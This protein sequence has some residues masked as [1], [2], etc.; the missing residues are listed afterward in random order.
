MR[1]QN[2]SYVPEEGYK[3][4]SH[5]W[6]CEG[7]TMGVEV[8]TDTEGGEKEVVHDVEC[9]YVITDG[10]EP[11]DCGVGDPKKHNC[12]QMLKDMSKV[13][14]PFY[15]KSDS[16]LSNGVELVSHPMTLRYV[17]SKKDE[18][19]KWRKA[20]ISNGFRCWDQK[21]AGI[22]IHTPLKNWSKTQLYRMMWLLYNTEDFCW[23]WCNRDESARNYCKMDCQYT[24]AKVAKSTRTE[25][26]NQV[27]TFSSKGTIEF[28]FFRSTSKITT[29]F[30]YFELI[31]AIYEY[32]RTCPFSSIREKGKDCNVD[33]K[34]F[35]G[36]QFKMWLGVMEHRYPNLAKKAKRW[37]SCEQKITT[38]LGKRYDYETSLLRG[39]YDELLEASGLKSDESVLRVED[40]F[41]K[42]EKDSKTYMLPIGDS[43]MSKLEDIEM[44]KV[45]AIEQFDSVEAAK[46]KTKNDALIAL[47]MTPITTDT[48]A[49]KDMMYLDR[50]GD[51]GWI[52][53]FSQYTVGFLFEH[54][55]VKAVRYFKL[56]ESTLTCEGVATCA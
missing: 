25:S 17:K 52:E 49:T 55:R 31:D 3:T 37:K 7:I 45:E 21:R 50:F 35:Y 27:F 53:G 6:D 13:G 12:S 20:I 36:L 41:L 1:V 28:R 56:N 8:E 43:I 51:W 47:G 44:K 34:N 24:P 42:V 33:R 26:R 11:C 18:W 38:T 9:E 15:A 5:K 22:H 39:K 23:F 29:L 10:A 40:K 16:S 4:H 2:Y 14:L 19:E 32:T 46:I 30:S 48:Q 54:K